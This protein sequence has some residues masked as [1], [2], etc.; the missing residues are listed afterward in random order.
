M[1]RKI[2]LFPDSRLLRAAQPVREVDDGVRKLLDDMVE[3]MVN[4]NGAGLAA[5]QIGEPYR[6][7]V[8]KVNRR[9]DGREEIVRLVNPVLKS[10]D[11][12]EVTA[13][14]GCLSFPGV[15]A[16]VTRPK[17]CVV[18][19]Q[20]ENGRELEIGG[21]GFLAVQLQHEVEHLDGKLLIDNITSDIKRS[22]VR[23]AMQKLKR[24]GFRYPDRSAAARA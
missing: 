15:F 17:S 22:Q 23:V 21:D 14:E 1:I 19:A 11:A 16:A 5:P 6:L 2:L 3:T 12:E 13:F 9:E 4:A 10:V 24:K 18:S 8:L 7:V 20:D